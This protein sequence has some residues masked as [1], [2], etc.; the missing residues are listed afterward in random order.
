VSG[1]T[2]RVRFKTCETVET[3]T[4]A[5]RA[6]SVIVATPLSPCMDFVD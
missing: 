3:E 6:T 4:P 1:A 2:R 5:L